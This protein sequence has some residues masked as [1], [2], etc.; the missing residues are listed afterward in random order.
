LVASRIKRQILEIGHDF[1][2]VLM[3]LKPE[4]LQKTSSYVGIDVHPKSRG[5]VKLRLE[6]LPKEMRSVEKALAIEGE[7]YRARHGN[8]NVNFMR[9]S[10][11]AMP[12]E[13]KSRFHVVFANN[14]LNTLDGNTLRMAAGKMHE[15]MNKNGLLIVTDTYGPAPEHPPELLEGIL[16]KAGF[17]KIGQ[18]EKELPHEVRKW[19]ESDAKVRDGTTLYCKGMPMQFRKLVTFTRRKGGISGEQISRHYANLLREPSKKS[20]K[21]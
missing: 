14:F 2:P 12:N 16:Y 5:L 1:K 17:R 3:R 7:T 8:P 9:M 11:F 18:G 20:T 6:Q 10:A 13:W 4:D 19:L 21:N 15:V